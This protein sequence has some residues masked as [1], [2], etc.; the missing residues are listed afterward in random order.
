[1][2]VKD[3]QDSIVAIS[4]GLEKS[5]IAV[6]RLSGRNCLEI[7]GKF[8]NPKPDLEKFVAGQI[9]RFKILDEKKELVDKALG[10]VY[11]SP[12]SYT[13]E[14]ML[15]LFC[16]GSP[17]I[18][19][20]ILSL[21]I[22]AGA[23]QA[24]PG[25]FTFRAFLNGKLSL[26]EAEAVNDLINSETEKQ[27]RAAISQLNGEISDKLKNFKRRLVNILAQIEVRLD[28]S[29]EEIS[30]LDNKSF[31]DCL[32]VL[33]KEVS[34]MAS[35]FEQG[36]FVKNGVN[37]VICGTP[38]CGKSSLLNKLAGYDKAIVSPYAGT[39]RDI[40]EET[41][42][43]DG[44]KFTFSDTAGLNS[45]T[46]D[47]VEEEGIK[48]SFKAIKKAD[49]VIFLRDS[50]IQSNVQED[51]S[52]KD[53]EQTKPQSTPI[54]EVFSKSDLLAARKPPKNAIAVSSLSGYG[55]EQLQKSL[56]SICQVKDFSHSCTVTSLRHYEALALCDK[57]LLEA[58]SNQENKGELE[59]TAEN[60][61]QA[62]RAIGEIV[63]E[64][65]TQE[66]LFEIFSNFCVGK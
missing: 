2:L 24:M 28:D 14:N 32:T 61:R 5:A 54:L 3:H 63:G 4:S 59:I 47:P 64:T 41:V 49:I 40:L 30:P 57:A 39:T 7:A 37:V 62:L 27:H 21:S 35:S 50:S 13:G 66:V 6:I 29:Y 16:H 11:I 45:Q 52:Y 58:L 56:V 33:E 53:I 15:E 51:R 26:N 12:K 48:R 43:I 18:I 55:I 60:I 10:V 19:R 22:K 25:E 46:S 8:L 20:K 17:Y 44:L 31:L 34:E 65:T 9:N 23:R 42:E 36:K 1:M 38:N